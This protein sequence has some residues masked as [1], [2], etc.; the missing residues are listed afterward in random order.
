MK[1]C[2]CE[3]LAPSVIP[4]IKHRP[5]LITIQSQVNPVKLVTAFNRIYKHY[6]FDLP[7][8]SGIF[9]VSGLFL[10]PNFVMVHSG[11]I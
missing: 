10:V 8:K 4:E 3:K 11:T 5:L 7:H 2:S 9:G 1:P 6:C